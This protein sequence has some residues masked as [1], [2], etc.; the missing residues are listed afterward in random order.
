MTTNEDRRAAADEARR[1]ADG[2]T[3]AQREA[4]VEGRVQ[5]CPYNHPKGTRCPNCAEWPFKKGG[6]ASTSA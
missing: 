3:V 5:D 1:I 4:V 6:A 2:L